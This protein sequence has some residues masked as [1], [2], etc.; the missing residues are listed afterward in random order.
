MV[1]TETATEAPKK[2]TRTIKTKAV[3]EGTVTP[4]QEATLGSIV[5]I[6]TK[7]SSHW[8]GMINPEIITIAD[9]KFIRGKQ[10]TGKDCHKMEGK[11]TL[12]PLEHV[13]SI[14][15]F[16]LEEDLWNESQPKNLPLPVDESRKSAVLTSHEQIPTKKRLAKPPKGFNSRFSNSSKFSKNR[17]PRFSERV[18]Y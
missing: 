8:Y 9:T 11:I 1:A 4:T 6:Y 13:A 18:D 12:V 16:E 7:S 15:E 17:Q 14:I 3:Q 10:I 5:M 2:R